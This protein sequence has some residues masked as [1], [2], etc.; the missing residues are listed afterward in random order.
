MFSNAFKNSPSY[1]QARPLTVNLFGEKEW[2]KKYPFVAIIR[3]P[4][5]LDIYRKNGLPFMKYIRCKNFSLKKFIPYMYFIIKNK[6]NSNYKYINFKKVIISNI[7]YPNI[8]FYGF[9]FLIRR[10]YIKIFKSI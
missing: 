4:E 10:I 3:I 2:S 9:F 1:I 5:I 8:Y 7:F 6:K